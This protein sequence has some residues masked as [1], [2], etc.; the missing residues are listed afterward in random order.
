MTT[1]CKECKGEG[2]KPGQFLGSPD[3]PCPVCAGA[4]TIEVT[5]EPLTAWQQEVV[6]LLRDLHRWVGPLTEIAERLKI[7]TDRA[8]F[9]EFLNGQLWKMSGDLMAAWDQSHPEEKP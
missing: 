1:P 4:G 8:V 6:T 7:E 3:D 9:M 2:K 5:E